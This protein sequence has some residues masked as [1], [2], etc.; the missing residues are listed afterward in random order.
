MPTVCRRLPVVRDSQTDHDC[1]GPKDWGP[2]V[3]KLKQVCSK[4]TI[5]VPPGCYRGKTSAADVEAAILKVPC[6]LMLAVNSGHIYDQCVPRRCC[7]TRGCL[8]TPAIS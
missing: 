5:K 2:R 8:E 1:A 3:A 7:R 4:A 6:W